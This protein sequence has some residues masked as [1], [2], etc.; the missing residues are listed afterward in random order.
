MSS[1]KGKTRGGTSGYKFFITLLKYLGIRSAYFFLKPI[2]L[3]YFLFAHKERKAIYQ[4]FHRVLKYSVA[5]SLLSI[6]KN[7]D[8]LG[9]VLLDKIVFLAGFNNKFTFDFDGEENLHEITEMGS[10]GL[11]IGAH[12]GNWEIAG[13]LLERIKTPVS[14]VLLDAEHRR[15]KELMDNVMVKRDMKIIPIKDDYSHLVKINEALNNNELVAI[16]GDRF[17]PGASTVNCEFLGITAKFPSGPFYLASKYNKPVVFVAAM[18]ETRDHYHFYAS[19]PKIYK[20][21]ANPKT[22]TTQLRNMVRDY[23]MYLDGIIRKYPLQW[24]NYYSF[25]EME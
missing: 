1:W 5:K 20:Y 22:R 18:K 19:R 3:Y 24:F 25:W 10:G 11:L 8:L 6:L 7:F 12:I 17:L 21:P 2:V 14:I 15:I 4:Y 13:K 23:V 16:H 9:Q